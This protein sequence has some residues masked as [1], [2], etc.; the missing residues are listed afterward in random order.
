LT[1]SPRLT[2]ESTG[3][4]SDVGRLIWRS[5]VAYRGIWVASQKAAEEFLKIASQKAGDSI[6][7]AREL[8]ELGYP[9]PAFVWA[10]RAVEIFYKEFLLAP[11]FYEGD[12]GKAVRR[13]NKLF[14]SSNW[15]RAVAKVDEVFGP[16]DK[17]IT[18]L[19]NDALEVWI[20]QIVRTRGDLVHGRI[21]ADAKTSEM[22]VAYADQLITQLKLRVVVTRKHPFSDVFMG[23]F[24]DAKTMYK[25]SQGTKE[26][27]ANG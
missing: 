4:Q 2:P 1:I 20:R 24:E 11:H 14:G 6:Q 19:G 7:V 22:A 8:L 23:I 12:W 17:M 21:N 9:S 26:E 3:G 15:D 5:S 10:V 13:A 27:D 16:L 25:A 18:E